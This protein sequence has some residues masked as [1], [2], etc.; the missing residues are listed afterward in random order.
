MAGLRGKAN[1]CHLDTL[2]CSLALLTYGRRQR[3]GKKNDCS[4]CLGISNFSPLANSLLCCVW[5]LGTPTTVGTHSR[6]DLYNTVKPRDLYETDPGRLHSFQPSSKVRDAIQK[7]GL[8]ACNP[9]LSHLRAILF[10]LPSSLSHSQVGLSSLGKLQ[11][12]CVTKDLEK[13]MRI[14]LDVCV[15]NICPRRLM[16]GRIHFIDLADVTIA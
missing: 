12:T 5:Q 2:D 10:H 14:F 11:A 9:R 7:S 1:Y 6:H 3:L 16:K 4:K 13:I 8:H 15:G